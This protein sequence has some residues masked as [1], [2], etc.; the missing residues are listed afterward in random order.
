MLLPARIKSYS[1]VVIAQEGKELRISPEVEVGS[2]PVTYPV[3]YQWKRIYSRVKRK[4]VEGATDGTLVFSGKDV[5]TVLN[6]AKFWLELT[7][8]GRTVR[9]GVIEVLVA[10]LMAVES[11]PKSQN[12]TAGE[13]VT[14]VAGFTG[15]PFIQW[16]RNGIDM[17]EATG[18]RH[19]FLATAADNNA[20]FTAE[21]KYPVLVDHKQAFRVLNYLRFLASALAFLPMDLQPAYRLFIFHQVLAQRPSV[22]SRGAKLTMNVGPEITIPLKSTSTQVGSKATFNFGVIGNVRYRW[23]RIFKGVRY[24][25][26]GETNPTF[27]TPDTTSVDDGTLYEAEATDENGLSV[28]SSAMLTVYD[29]PS[30]ILNP[31]PWITDPQDVEVI[32][33]EAASIGV[34]VYLGDGPFYYRLYA[35]VFK[36]DFTLDDEYALNKDHFYFP[37]DRSNVS[38]RLVGGSTNPK[39]TIED[40]K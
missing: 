27:T 30:A 15:D 25:L 5:T 22:T 33:G 24:I 11:H 8:A 23:F 3:T 34:E 28:T 14:L 7:S 17:P 29:K 35:V 32:E 38:Y 31:I 18:P 6:H 10:P 20:I 2:D 1:K 16:Q 37:W 40:A 21:A 4:P 13:K 26:Y 9:T 36:D 12:F 39:Y 19:E